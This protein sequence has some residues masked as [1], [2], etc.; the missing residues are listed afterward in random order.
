[1]NFKAGLFN[2]KEGVY[3]G[4][5]SIGI[6]NKGKTTITNKQKNLL[7]GLVLPKFKKHGLK[8]LEHIQLIIKLEQM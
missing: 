8:N 4:I 2:P 1:M 6:M 3:S 5:E 7:I